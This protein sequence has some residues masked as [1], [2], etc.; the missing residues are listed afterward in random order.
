MG[1]QMQIVVSQEQGRIPVT[2]FHL[3]GQID[4]D[5]YQE[6]EKRA[7]EAYDA[8]SRA[9]VL[10]LAKV[11]YMSSAG[12]RALHTIFTIFRA[13]T[14]DQTDAEVRRGVVAGTFKSAQLKLLNPKPAV[15]EVIKTAG[16]DMFLEI[17]HKLK[18][19]VASF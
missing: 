8:G 12:L 18:D 14:P 7:R 4:A 11:T 16:F 1:S 5:S 6:L 19:A 13:A 17:H 9:L 2:V 15:L 3:S 10:D